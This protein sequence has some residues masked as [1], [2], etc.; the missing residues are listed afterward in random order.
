[1][2]DIR[3][4]PATRLD[5]DFLGTLYAASR[6]EEVGAA[7]WPDDVAATFLVSQRAAQETHYR[8]TH[9]DSRHDVVLKGRR[10]IGRLWV[11]R[12]PHRILLVDISLIPTVRGQGIGTQLIGDLIDQATETNRAV[13]LSVATRNT[14]AAALYRRL[15]L[16]EVDRTDTH[17]AMSTATC[18]AHHHPTIRTKRD[19]DQHVH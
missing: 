3:F 16:V 6:A 8:A 5:D 19:G 7:G 9:P 12:S 15:G 18:S 2:D 4:R 13:E 11:D 10:A 1:M 17:I 14:R